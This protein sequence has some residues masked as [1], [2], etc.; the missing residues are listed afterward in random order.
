[1][2][3]NYQPI[4]TP[5]RPVLQENHHKKSY[6]VNGKCIQNRNISL[7]A[8]VLLTIYVLRADYVHRDAHSIYFIGGKFFISLATRDGADA[9]ATAGDYFS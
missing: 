6:T 8:A 2:N 3:K 4:R 1:L 5:S 7:T 9:C